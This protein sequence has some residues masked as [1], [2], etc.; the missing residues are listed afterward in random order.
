VRYA[1]HKSKCVDNINM[2]LTEFN[3]LA[4]VN[5]VMIL[6]NSSKMGNFIDRLSECQILK[7]DP[8]PCS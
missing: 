7:V 2:D 4:V 8:T 6:R 1:I 3:S 5:V